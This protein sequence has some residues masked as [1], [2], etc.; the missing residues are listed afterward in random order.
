M[1]HLLDQGYSNI[2]M[3]DIAKEAL[4]LSHHRLGAQAD[5]VRWQVA[6]ITEFLSDRS[7]DLWHDH[8][9]LHFLTTPGSVLLTVQR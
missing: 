2:M 5:Q 6:D 4:D 1:D 9:V 8:A 3:L 7:Y